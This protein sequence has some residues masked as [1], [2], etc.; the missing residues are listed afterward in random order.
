M[1]KL[2]EVRVDSKHRIVLPEEVR[3][4]SG[5]KIGSKMRVSMKNRSIIL[6]KSVDADEFIRRMEGIL[7]DG[8]PVHV[9]D[10]I[11]LKEIW[12]MR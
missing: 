7:K 8:S 4:K 2:E 5:V 12:A 3:R 11:K 6:S 1:G 10:P 9:S